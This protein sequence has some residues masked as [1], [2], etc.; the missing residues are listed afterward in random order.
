MID[1]QI[2]ND[3]PTY[4]RQ[5][6]EAD[7]EVLSADEVQPVVCNECG[8]SDR[9]LYLKRRYTNTDRWYA[10]AYCIRCTRYAG[11]ARHRGTLPHTHRPNAVLR[12]SRDAKERAGYK[13]QV[14]G[15]TDGLVVHHI[16]GY[17]VDPEYRTTPGNA[18]VLC[19]ACHEK[20]HRHDRYHDK[21][22]IAP[23]V[24]RVVSDDQQDEQEVIER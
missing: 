2:L 22:F 10:V 8:Q 11:T 13:C 14:C 4:I 16:V 7:D 17:A 3:L 12:W 9:M 5:R 18:A 21:F 23:A 1:E 15:S 24:P 20:A 19:A 6:I